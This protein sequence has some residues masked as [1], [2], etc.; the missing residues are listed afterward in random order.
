MIQICEM[1]KKDAENAALLERQIFSQPWSENGFLNAL[2]L[3][4]TIFL[5]AKEDERVVGY[6]GMYRSLDEGE[7]TNVAVAPDVRR[8]GIGEKL[9]HKLF[10]LAEEKGVEKIILEVRVSNDSAVRLY[11]KNGF[12]RCGI[13]KGFYEFPKEDA[14]IY[15]REK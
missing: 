10:S 15:C 8:R 6:V 2:Q 12:V 11:E 1:Q 13:R 5:V 4:N 3:E 14:Y 7:I 9:L